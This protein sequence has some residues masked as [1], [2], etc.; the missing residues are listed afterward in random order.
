MILE[1]GEGGGPPPSISARL[2]DN[3]TVTV[4]FDGKLQTAPTVNGPW[5]DVSGASPLVLPADQ[6]K[7]FGRAVR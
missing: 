5:Q 3:G 7:R 2:N 1:E 4:T 6:A